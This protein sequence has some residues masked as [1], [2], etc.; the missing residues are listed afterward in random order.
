[1]LILSV[2]IEEDS[3]LVCQP[4]VRWTDINEI[5]KKKGM[6]DFLFSSITMVLD[7][8]LQESLSSFRYEHI[9]SRMASIFNHDK[10]D[11]GPGATIGGMLSTGC[12]GSMFSGSIF[13][14]LPHNDHFIPANAVRYGTAK[15]EWFLNAV[16]S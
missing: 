3:D 15:G 11:P 13:D 7:T 14:Q 2:E 12:S 5:L 1:M 6:N 4:A 10:I 16:G 9:L 8:L